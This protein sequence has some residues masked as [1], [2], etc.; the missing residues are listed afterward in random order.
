LISDWQRVNQHSVDCAEDSSAG[1][2]ADGEYGERSQCECRV[3]RQDPD[4]VAQV[5]EWR[6]NH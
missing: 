2:D 1:A 6:V 3:F 4:G 5:F